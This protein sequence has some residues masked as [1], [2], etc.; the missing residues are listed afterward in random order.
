MCIR[1]RAYYREVL[2]RVRQAPGVRL[3]G[4]TRNLPLLGVAEQWPVIV[5]GQPAVASGAEP[6]VP[7]H[8]VSPDYFRAMGIPLL[9]GRAFTA[10]DDEHAVAVAIISR[11]MAL[12][13][14]PTTDPIGRSFRFGPQSVTVVGV[15]GDIR[16]ARLDAEG[17][18][19]FYV[20]QLQDPRR[21]F[22]LVIRT[23][24]DPRAMEAT[25]R[26]E[27]RAVDPD[28]PII[29]I[30]TMA[31][32]LGDAVTQPRLMS[33]LFGIFGVL[34]LGLA[35]LGIYGVLAYTVSLRTHELGIRMALGATP[36]D[37]MMMILR[38]GV[39]M[40]IAGVALGML[41]APGLTRLMTS[42]LYEISATDPVTFVAVAGLV[43][44]TGLLASYIPSH[45]ATQVD[46]LVSLR[47]E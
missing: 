11:S 17:A 45:R 47:C 4:S 7:E 15:V 2:D 42:Q 13:F 44:V 31:E 21:G 35:M 28:H 25:L 41:L 36:R 18:P 27:I 43:L 14:W 32:V 26:H 10:A 29:R 12:R 30:A 24:G 33:L 46:P 20:P 8:Q 3:A 5:E 39:R 38:D 6:L 19:E 9:Q 22:P 37:T 1:D 34:A 23:V 16:Q 40:A